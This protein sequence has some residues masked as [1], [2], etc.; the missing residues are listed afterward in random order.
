MVEGMCVVSLSFVDKVRSMWLCWFL[1][2]LVSVWFGVCLGLGG[3]VGLLC[4][5]GLRFCLVFLAMK[6]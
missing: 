6:N 1:D 4:C 3:G 5:W 2:F